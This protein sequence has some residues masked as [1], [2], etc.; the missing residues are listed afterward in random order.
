[1]SAH[2]S[3]KSTNP[4]FRR[5]TRSSF[6]PVIAFFVIGWALRD[7]PTRCLRAWRSPQ[8][9]NCERG[10]EDFALQRETGR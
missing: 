1:M 3:P 6:N 5:Q 8:I 2:S 7:E 10:G 9:A 4:L